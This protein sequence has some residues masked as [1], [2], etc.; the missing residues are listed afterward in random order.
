L[1]VTSFYP[2]CNKKFHQ[3]IIRQFTPGIAGGKYDISHVQIPEHFELAL[4]ISVIATMFKNN[5]PLV[6]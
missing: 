1:L 5:S 6:L 2:V 4:K 3:I